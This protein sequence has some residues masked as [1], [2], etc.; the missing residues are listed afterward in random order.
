MRQIAAA[1]DGLRAKLAELL[2]DIGQRAVLRPDRRA[3]KPDQ[4]SE[5]RCPKKP[6][7]RLLPRPQLIDEIEMTV[8][9]RRFCE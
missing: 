2:P 7:D 1:I 6:H 5:D 8:T 3:R 4:P 9:E